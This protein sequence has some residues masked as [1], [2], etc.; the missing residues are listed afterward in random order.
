MNQN[1]E[2][3]LRYLRQGFSVLPLDP[4]SKEPVGYWAP[5]QYQPASEKVIRGRWTVNPDNNVGVIT[6]A[7]ATEEA[8]RLVIFDFD[9]PELYAKHRARLPDKTCTVSSGRAGGKHVWILAPEPIATY[10]LPGLDI[11]GVG[12]Y[13]VAPPSTHAN[14]QVY[15]FET[16]PEAI[17]EMSWSELE[18]FGVEP[19]ARRLKDRRP[20]WIPRTAWMI[21]GGACGESI[22]A[23][24]SRSEYEFVVVCALLGVGAKPA[25]IYGVFL[26]FAHSG[27]K[28]QELRSTHG[29]KHAESWLMRT[30]ESARRHLDRQWASLNESLKTMLQQL[31]KMCAA[32]AGA[33]ELQS[34]YG[35]FIQA[36]RRLRKT[37][38]DVD[39][40]TL[41]EFAGVTS[42]TVGAGIRRL[43]QVG[44]VRRVRESR[45]NKSSRYELPEYVPELENRIQFPIPSKRGP[46]DVWEIESCFDAEMFLELMNH[47]LFVAGGLGR[48]ALRLWIALSVAGREGR[49][50]GDLADGLQLAPETVRRNAKVMAGANMIYRERR[51]WRVRAAIDLDAIASRL[52]YAGIGTS[53]Q[54]QHIADRVAFE[55][56][57]GIDRR[58][59][60]RRRALQ[61]QGVLAGPGQ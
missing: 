10:N 43:I 29:D 26:Q 38:F 5:Y 23:R 6:C 49:T 57:L 9:D 4:R 25:D 19:F 12:G 39:V 41:A 55:T 31:P 32:S 22:K 3:A 11:K 18:F 45:A 51:I 56:R 8:R 40:R 1:L 16:G 33:T 59:H 28:F 34:V 21:L 24:A 17:A 44:A 46:C 15:E 20:A 35:A 50:V 53:R 48:I 47:D 27:S 58:E 36:A 61:V 30:V 60:H 54:L 7:G 14:G 13:C 52:G 2:F 42:R 37:E